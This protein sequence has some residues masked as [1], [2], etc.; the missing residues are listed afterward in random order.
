MAS[1]LRFSESV[2][3]LRIG[4]FF[5]CYLLLEIPGALLISALTAFVTTPMEFYAARF[6]PGVAEAGFFPG[7]IVY[8]TRWF[9]SQ[10][11]SV[12]QWARPCRLRLGLCWS[13]MEYYRDTADDATYRPFRDIDYLLAVRR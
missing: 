11:R 2:F 6:F 10:D 13:P 5:I 8:F 12:W 3:G 1:D 7:I 4:I 9:S